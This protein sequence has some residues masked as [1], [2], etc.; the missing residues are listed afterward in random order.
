MGYREIVG[1]PALPTGRDSPGK[2]IKRCIP[3]LAPSGQANTF[4]S[5]SRSRQHF[6]NRQLM[7]YFLFFFFFFF[8]LQNV[9]NIVSSIIYMCFYFLRR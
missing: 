8:F 2:E 6:E 3:S 7:F 5:L 4:S 9:I 1:F